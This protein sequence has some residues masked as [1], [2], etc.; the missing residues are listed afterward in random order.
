MRPYIHINCAMSADGK[1]AGIE[2]KQ[3]R[4]SSDE[5]KA[6]VKSLRMKYDAILV[7]VGTV[8]SDDPH[9]T[10]KGRT[11]EENQVRIVIDPHGRT[12][13]E[14]QVADGRAR[15]VIVTADDCARLWEGCET[16]RSPGGRIDLKYVMESLG[17]V[18]IGSVLVEGGGTTIAAFLKE[19]LFDVLTIYVGS[20][21]IG[22]SGAPSPADGPGWVREGGLPLSLRDVS[23]CGDGVVLEYV[24]R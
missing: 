5:D 6:R 4:I 17:S 1:I 16:L 18:G 13:A 12:P 9:L 7:G 3:V 23:R 11:K 2:R 22:G 20:M 8:L 24:P 15:T 10:V 21:V 14:A 19:G